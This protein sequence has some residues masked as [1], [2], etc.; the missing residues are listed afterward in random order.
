MV[1][2]SLQFILGFMP[3]FFT[4]YYLTPTQLRNVT[5]LIGSLVFYAIGTYQTPWHYALFIFFMVFDFYCGLAI[6]KNKRHK[7]LFLTFAII[8]HVFALFFVKYFSFVYQQITLFLQGK[9]DILNIILPIGISFYTFQGISY[10]I[11]VYQ[12]KIKAERDL[13]KYCVYI[14][15]FPQ[16]IAGPIVTFNQIKKNLDKRDITINRA[17]FGLYIFIFGLALKVLLANP[18]GKCWNQ[19]AA[20]GY[21]SITTPLAWIAIMAYTFQIYFDFFGYSLMAIGL[22]KMLGFN[23]PKNFH[24][25]Y[26]SVS[27]TDF[28]RRW[29][30]TLGSWF[31]NYVY[32][33]LGGNRVSLIKLIRNLFIVWILT[34]IWHGAG[35]HFVIWGLYLFMLIAIEKLFLS[36]FLNK[37][38][39]IGHIYMI[40]VI[41]IS[42]SIFAI[43]DMSQLYI[44]LGRLFP[45]NGNLGGPFPFDYFKYL[46]NYWIFLIV[47]VIL[48]FPKVYQQFMKIKQP[49]M[50]ALIMLTLLIACL[51]CMKI[52]LD[53]PFL[54]FRF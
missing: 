37:Y 20:I 46:G 17:L 5:L 34:A 33:P 36:N 35:Y 2:S 3:I 53:D 29:H 18:L 30:I 47:G 12:N 4:I 26:A 51:Y 23:F 52:G 25:P 48:C 28:W 32:I 14:S 41:S 49:L 24:H 38:R 10:L 27:L 13:L 54:Y 8:N 19:V 50:I 44:F 21:E 1:F 7:S 31:R 11:D 9:E 6:Q 42:W 22:G 16:L 40:F 43:E 39:F 15:M 45:L